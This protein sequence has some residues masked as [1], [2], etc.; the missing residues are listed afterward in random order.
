MEALLS[1]TMTVPITQ[2]I[3]A[4]VFCTFFLIFNRIRLALLA[5]YCFVLYWAKPW[6]LDLYTNSVPPTLNGPVCLFIAFCMITTLLTITG[7][8]FTRD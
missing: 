8:A 5:S 7:I 6:S 4:L 1:T 3:M 2:I